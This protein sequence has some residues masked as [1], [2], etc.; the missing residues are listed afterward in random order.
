[1]L[2]ALRAPRVC[3]GC[4]Q[5]ASAVLESCPH[6]LP[7]PKL[8]VL[9]AGLKVWNSLLLPPPPL[10][11]L[12]HHSTAIGS[13]AIHACRQSLIV[14]A[15][16]SYIPVDCVVS[17]QALIARDLKMGV[18]LPLL[19]QRSPSKLRD[20]VQ[21]RHGQVALKLEHG[22]VQGIFYH[23]LHYSRLP[24][25]IHPPPPS[26][27]PAFTPSSAEANSTRTVT[28]VCGACS[29][30][31]TTRQTPTPSPS[32]ARCFQMICQTRWNA[33]TSTTSSTP[34]WPVGGHFNST[35]RLRSVLMIMAAGTSYD[36][37]GALFRR[38]SSPRAVGP[39]SCLSSAQSTS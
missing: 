2:H 39:P 4:K 24:P 21:A 13:T 35:R 31:Y 32:I 15:H 7:P 36:G 26:A 16:V 30:C 11:P 17:S 29:S 10:P 9:I 23:P 25:C 14:S 27:P 19:L 38:P 1:M 28:S 34:S 37:G 12:T 8:P 18:A 33:I 5:H 20:L 22:C 6:S 3:D